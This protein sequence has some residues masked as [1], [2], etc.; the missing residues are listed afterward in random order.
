MGQN[1]RMN[2][3]AEGARKNNLTLHSEKCAMKCS[4]HTKWLAPQ[5]TYP[6]ISCQQY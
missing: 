3:D 5:V 2:S 6:A 1:F 4:D